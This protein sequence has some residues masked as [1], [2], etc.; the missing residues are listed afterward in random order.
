VAHKEPQDNEDTRP[1]ALQFLRIVLNDFAR[2]MFDHLHLSATCRNSPVQPRTKVVAIHDC[3]SGEFQDFEGKCDGSRAHADG[4][5]L[6]TI[7]VNCLQ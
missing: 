6:A 7:T 5:W 1:L 3:D 2:A 4:E